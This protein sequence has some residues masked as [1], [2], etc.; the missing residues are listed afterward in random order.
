MTT[1]PFTSQLIWAA[2]LEFRS[3]QKRTFYAWAYG[4]YQAKLEYIDF[5][6]AYIG[7]GEL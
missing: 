5:L 7:G 6:H 3:I 4:N 1:F 2:A